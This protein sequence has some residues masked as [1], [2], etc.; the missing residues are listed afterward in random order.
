MLI[1]INYYPA[2]IKKL[3]LADLPISNYI[4]TSLKNV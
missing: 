1:F 2:I 3:T 4:R